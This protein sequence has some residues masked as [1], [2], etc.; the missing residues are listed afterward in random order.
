MQNEDESD[1][2]YGGDAAKET[3]DMTESKCWVINSLLLCSCLH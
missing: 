1:V 2:V 3:M